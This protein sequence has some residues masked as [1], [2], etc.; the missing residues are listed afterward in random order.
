MLG[1]VDLHL[2][3]EFLH[4]RSA[5][6]GAGAGASAGAGAGGLSAKLFKE[7]CNELNTM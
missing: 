1:V 2:L 7:L 5:S 6:A 4:L 3:L